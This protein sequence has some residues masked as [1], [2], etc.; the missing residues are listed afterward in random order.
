MEVKDVV[1]VDR[2]D[3]TNAYHFSSDALSRRNGRPQ[4]CTRIPGNV[5]ADSDHHDL[6]KTG[7]QPSKSRHLPSAIHSS[8]VPLA[9]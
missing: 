2:V 4:G 8:D 9:V 7:R 1:K 6:G 5:A 3:N